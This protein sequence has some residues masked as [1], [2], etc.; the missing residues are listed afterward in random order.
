MVVFRK[1]WEARQSEL[2]KL[3]HQ[4]TK[5]RLQV[6]CSRNMVW[7]WHTGSQESEGYSLL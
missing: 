7:V 1:T 4:T 5:V 2:D 3:K 6:L